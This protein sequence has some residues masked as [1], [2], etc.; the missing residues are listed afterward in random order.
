MTGQS[1]DSFPVPLL[2]IIVSLDTSKTDEIDITF[3]VVHTR[4]VDHIN[5]NRR[6][7]LRRL[8]ER[9]HNSKSLFLLRLLTVYPFVP[10]VGTGKTQIVEEFSSVTE[11]ILSPATGVAWVPQVFLKKAVSTAS[12]RPRAAAFSSLKT[13]ASS[14]SN[15]LTINT[16]ISPSHAQW[17]EIGGFF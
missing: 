14:S 2:E 1:S 10:T 15:P 5:N 17:L 16:T 11:Q 4:C 7:F 12:P 3:S 13:S 8:I 9:E 6:F